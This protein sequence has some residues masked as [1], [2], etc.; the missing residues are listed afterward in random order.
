MTSRSVNLPFNATEIIDNLRLER[1]VPAVDS[2]SP[3]ISGPNSIFRRLYYALR[4]LFPVSFRRILQRIALQN[5]AKIPFPTWPVDTTVE[6]FISRLW[7]LALKASGEE[8]LPFIWYWPRG[9]DACA[10][11]THDVETGA[12]QDF[13]YRMLEFERKHGIRS[14]FE[15]VPELR[16]EISEALVN[17]IRAAGCEVCIHGLTHDDK[18]FSSER[19]F[20]AQAT[21]INQYAKNLG[22]RGFRSPVMYRNPTWYDAFEFS[23]DM[24]VPNVAHL[25]PQRGG[26]CT[27]FPFFIGDIVELPLTTIQDY[28][29]YNILRSN[30]LQMWSSQL[31]TI[32]GKYGLVSFLIHPD[33]T[34]TPERQTLYCELLGLIKTFS[35]QRNLWLALPREVDEWWRQRNDMTLSQVDGKWI[36]QGEGSDRASI[37]YARLERGTVSFVTEWQ[38]LSVRTIRDF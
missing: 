9:F 1:Y 29:I 2:E 28:P 16:Y 5:W 34:M 31:E 12:G 35:V 37:A 38:D 33:Y 17:A 36:I 3:Y 13:C 18:L 25:D 6:D 32:L 19:E 8:Q 10:I 21:K 14:S 7:I 23:Y 27:V 11:M 26:C 15:F 24:S 20:R 4:P 22:A 30:P